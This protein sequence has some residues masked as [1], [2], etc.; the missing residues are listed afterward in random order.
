M[1][2]YKISLKPQKQSEMCTAIWRSGSS[3]SSSSVSPLSVFIFKLCLGLSTTVVQLVC[4]FC[5]CNKKC[6][7]LLSTPLSRGL[8]H[9]V[10]TIIMKCHIQSQ[11]KSCCTSLLRVRLQISVYSSLVPGHCDEVSGASDQQLWN[12]LLCDHYILADGDFE[13]VCVWKMPTG[14]ERE[15]R[16]LRR[17]WKEPQQNGLCHKG[18]YWLGL[19]PCDLLHC[20]VLLSSHSSLSL[21]SIY[22]G[23]IS[24]VKC[25]WPY[26]SFLMWQPAQRSHC[27]SNVLP[28]ET[29]AIWL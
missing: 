16:M 14:E 23:C 27:D 10:T 5:C 28:L 20:F 19:T 25:T 7:L 26:N 3:G 18:S 2:T 17:I 22:D 4:G 13:N 21:S 12:C 9:S 6:D 8:E 11:N 15:E 1:I 24:Q 29:L